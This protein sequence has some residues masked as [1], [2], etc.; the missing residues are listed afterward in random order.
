MSGDA[1]DA[2]ARRIAALL[3]AAHSDPLGVAVSGGSDSTALLLAA[4]A[5]SRSTGIG[6]HVVTVDHGLRPEA[7]AEARQVA[8]L[9]ESLGHPHEVIR[10]RVAPGPNL[11]A[12]ARTARYDA[13]AEAAPIGREAVL[14]GHTADDVAETM[15]MRLARASGIDGL[16][17]MAEGRHDRNLHWL[18][19]ALTV[20]RADLRAALTARRIGWSE[21]SS[22]EDATFERVAARQAIASLGLDVASIAASAAVLEEARISLVAH[23]TQIAARYVREDRGDLLLDRAALAALH[24]DDPDPVPRILLAALRWIGGRPYGPRHAERTRFVANALEGRTA[25]LAGC[26]MS[27]ETGT[28]RIAREAAFCAPPGPTDRPWDVRWH[29]SGPHRPGLTVG[30]LGHDITQTPWREAGLPRMSLLASPAIRD[31]TRLIA[32]P[33]AGLFTE[34]SVSLRPTFAQVLI[35]R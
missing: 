15:M 12:R 5:V 32:A 22:N 26:R 9:C 2:V 13:I 28:L 18:R 27:D 34:W 16:A 24:A 6:L 10:L 19:P 3:T 11:Q 8:A 20:R 17:R 7:Q 4:D 21:D 35:A 29:C 25:T 23:A 1:I 33:L 31:G 14:L 30:A